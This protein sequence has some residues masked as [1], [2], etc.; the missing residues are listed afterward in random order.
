MRTT[1]ARGLLD[2]AEWGTVSLAR[3]IGGS[4]YVLVP[5]EYVGHEV[6]VVVLSSRTA[7]IQEALNES[8]SGGRTTIRL[9]RSPKRGKGRGP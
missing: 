2:R 5:R 8:L 9:S 3:A 4:A 6:V 1:P 7:G